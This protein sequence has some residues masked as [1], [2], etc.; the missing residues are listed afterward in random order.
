[1][2][3]NLPPK[4]D[5]PTIDELETFAIVCKA[6]PVIPA[7]LAAAPLIPPVAIIDTIKGAWFAILW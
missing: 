6:L 2:S 5:K 7:D 4:L 1:M 3:E